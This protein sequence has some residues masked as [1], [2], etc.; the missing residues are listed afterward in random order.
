VRKT[1]CQIKEKESCKDRKERKADVLV[2]GR[3]DD[4][5]GGRVRRIELARRAKRWCDLL[6]ELRNEPRKKKK[7]KKDTYT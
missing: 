1:K 5:A 7:T 6:Q 4:A 3:V 2:L